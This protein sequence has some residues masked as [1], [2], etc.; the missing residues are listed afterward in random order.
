MCPRY[1]TVGACLYING[2]Q[3]QRALRPRILKGFFFPFQ[4]VAQNT[5]TQIRTPPYVRYTS[6]YGLG[7]IVPTVSGS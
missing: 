1:R 7:Y 4:R 3:D 2:R 5:P 6:C